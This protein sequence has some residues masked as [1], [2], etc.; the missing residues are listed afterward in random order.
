MNTN[1][2]AY[3]A[4]KHVGGALKS[5]ILSKQN[6]DK[7]WILRR[8]NTLVLFKT[9]L[10]QVC[11]PVWTRRKILPLCCFCPHSPDLFLKGKN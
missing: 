4:L 9:R 8:V 6:F 1:L 3:I 7:S 10:F 2:R 11:I 5:G